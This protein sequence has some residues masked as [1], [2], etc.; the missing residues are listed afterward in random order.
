MLSSMSS[1]SSSSDSSENYSS[2]SSSNS[3]S[4]SS[5]T[6]NAYLGPFSSPRIY[7]YEMLSYG[8]VVKYENIPEELG[9]IE[10]SYMVM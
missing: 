6:S 8:F 9:Y 2:S 3:S 1:N 5:S 7:V 10:F 4:S